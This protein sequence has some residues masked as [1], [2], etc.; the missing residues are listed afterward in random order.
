MTRWSKHLAK[1]NFKCILFNE[2]IWISNK[3]VPNGL[4]FPKGSG[5]IIW[6]H[7]CVSWNK[8]NMTNIGGSFEILSAPVPPI[9]GSLSHIIMERP[10]AG[11][12]ITCHQATKKMHLKMLQTASHFI[13]TSYMCYTE[14][15]MFSFWRNFHHWLHLNFRSSDAACD[16]I[17]SKWQHFCFRFPFLFP[18]RFEVLSTPF[19]TAADGPILLYGE[20]PCWCSHAIRQVNIDKA[21]QPSLSPGSADTLASIPLVL[22]SIGPDGFQN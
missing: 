7:F 5:V 19:S 17:S 16:E 8:F 11:V 10:H 20:S 12:P 9:H 6:I 15:E 3:Y 22:K 14:T 1:N 2:Y 4:T 21:S 13:Q 18:F